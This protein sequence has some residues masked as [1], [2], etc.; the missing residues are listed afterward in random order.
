MSLQDLRFYIQFWE[1]CAAVSIEH[2]SRGIQ[3]QIGYGLRKEVKPE[4]FINIQV[5]NRC[6]YANLSE[7][8]NGK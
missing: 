7:C 1:L 3:F 5:I 2:L 4:H 8:I 6:K